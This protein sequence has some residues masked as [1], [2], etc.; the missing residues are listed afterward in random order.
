MIATD[1]GGEGLNLQFC[2]NLINYD[3]PWNPMN[4][5]Q[6]IGRIDRIGQQRGE[7]SEGGRGAIPT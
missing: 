4:I 1:V 2:R 3:L 7:P 6:R 5:E